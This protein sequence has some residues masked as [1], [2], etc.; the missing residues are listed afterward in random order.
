[1]KEVRFFIFYQQMPDLRSFT[2]E[3]RWEALEIDA[4]NLYV[5]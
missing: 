3:K 5:T 2:L 1:M 4:R